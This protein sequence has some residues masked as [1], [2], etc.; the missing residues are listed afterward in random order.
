VVEWVQIYKHVKCDH[1]FKKRIGGVCWHKRFKQTLDLQVVQH[2]QRQVVNR[3][4]RRWCTKQ[5]PNLKL[6]GLKGA[7]I[8]NT[9]QNTTTTNINK[10]GT[11]QFFGLTQ[12]TNFDTFVINVGKI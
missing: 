12:E 11:R 4:H 10:I 8:K 1:T 2:F 7:I 6:E 3:K 9:K 5:E